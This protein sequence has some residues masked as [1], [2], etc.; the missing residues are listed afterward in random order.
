MF[1][2]FQR[3][4]EDGIDKQIKRILDDMDMFGPGSEEYDKL[5][6]QLK[7]LMKL[8]TNKKSWHIDPNTVVLVVGNLVGILIIVMYEEKHVITSKAYSTFVKMVNK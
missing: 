5:L 4:E 3:T 6:P 8:K 2:P 1:G 7:K